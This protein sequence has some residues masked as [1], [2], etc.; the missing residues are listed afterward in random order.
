MLARPPAEPFR[1]HRKAR[2]PPQERSSLLTRTDLLAGTM[3]VIER[4]IHAVIIVVVSVMM[5]NMLLGVFSRFI[6]HLGI[7]FTE[8]LG[9][10]LM[11]WA[12]YLGCV[13]A[14]NEGSHIAVGAIVA[15]FPPGV[16]KIVNTISTVIVTVFLI[17]VVLTS[18]RHL[19]GLKIQKSSALEIPMVIPYVSVTVGAGLMAVV[20]ILRLLGYER[21]PAP[22]QA[23]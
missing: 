8:E 11:V 14:L 9:R 4:V 5:V 10:Y 17:L 13:L 1:R 3:K 21:P 22:A 7:P 23:K 2:D 18:F 6:F 20:N 19:E 12:G 15:S 16:Q